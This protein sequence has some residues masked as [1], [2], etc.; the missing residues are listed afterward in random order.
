M[1]EEGEIALDEEAVYGGDDFVGPVDPGQYDY[2]GD[3]STEPVDFTGPENPSGASEYDTW[4]T[5]TS[6]A[7]NFVGPVNPFPN[8][9]ITNEQ[10]A[11]ESSYGKDSW[12]DDF[13][14]GFSGGKAGKGTS[15]GVSL[16]GSKGGSKG[17]K[18]KKKKSKPPAKD[19]ATGSTKPPAGVAWSGY[20][21]PVT[22][23]IFALV[24]VYLLARKKRG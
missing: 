5:F 7:E 12:W 23:I 20:I 4:D 19:R 8:D 2:P 14:A 18:D 13:L 11:A 22:V 6:A 21:L 16:G 1:A 9:P 3:P 17:A 10:A 24:I 15:S